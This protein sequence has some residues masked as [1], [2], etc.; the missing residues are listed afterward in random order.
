MLFK[1]VALTVVNVFRSLVKSIGM[2]ALVIY[3]AHE[4]EA[5]EMEAVAETAAQLSQR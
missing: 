4:I 3:V 2:F 1:G 5:A